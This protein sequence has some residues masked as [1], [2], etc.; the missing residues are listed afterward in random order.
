MCDGITTLLTPVSI[1]RID[2]N[3]EVMGGCL[4]ISSAYGP[5]SHVFLDSDER[6][7]H[8]L[9]EKALP[10]LKPNT[11]VHQGRI[12]HTDPTLVLDLRDGAHPNV[13]GVPYRIVRDYVHKHLL[14]PIKARY[15]IKS[16]VPDHVLLMVLQ[17]PSL[18]PQLL[19]MQAA[20]RFPK[21]AVGGIARTV[22]SSSPGYPQDNRV[23]FDEM[24][25]FFSV[26]P[27]SCGVC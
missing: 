8:K 27:K 12:K 14:A 1:P 20:Q 6:T 10:S 25:L 4:S 5:R 15:S 21:I 17:D 19:D 23:R 24:L 9:Y 2:K 16:S 7:G 3:E 26:A 13:T 11:S 18:T 22:V